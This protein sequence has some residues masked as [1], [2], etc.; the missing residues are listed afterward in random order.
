M[1]VMNGGF[2]NGPTDIKEYHIGYLNSGP[3]DNTGALQGGT[4]N[5]YFTILKE[6]YT[7]ASVQG[8]VIGEHLK[9]IIVAWS[10]KDWSIMWA[11]MILTD[12]QIIP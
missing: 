12:I 5:S 11:D 7:D 9:G 3:V 8:W 6:S 2:F 10:D 4:G 1:P